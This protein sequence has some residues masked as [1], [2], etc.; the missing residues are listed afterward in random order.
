MLEDL[1][2]YIV[3]APAVA[4]W[5]QWG[6]GALFSTLS[7]A[8]GLQS[9]WRARIID[10]TPT[11]K[12]RSAPQGYV[13]L[14]GTMAPHE[15]GHNG[16]LTGRPCIWYR[17]A[18]HERRG[19]GKN[20]RWV[21]IDGGMSDAPLRLDDGT[22]Q[23]VI[24]P[25][26]AEII[27]AQNDSWYGNSRRPSPTTR[28]SSGLFSGGYRYREERI[29]AGESGYAIGHLHT[30][31][32]G[33]KERDELAGHLLK[34]WKND[35]AA[36]AR[37]DTD[38]DGELSMREWSAAVD[39]AERLASEAEARVKRP[40]PMAHLSATGEKRHPFIIST[41][42]EH[43]LTRRFKLRAAFSTLIF[44]AMGPIT[45]MALYIRLGTT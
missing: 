42:E 27:C 40:P 14:H 8:S 29:S 13:E 32:R 22:G 41:R 10:D 17:W 24:N 21:R 33:R 26:G 3:H 2:H 45:L 12:L 30:P 37:F 1:H 25:D 36:R 16:P 43:D 6:F 34:R 11:A 20:S 5:P 31:R 35:P 7:L 28:T 23:C 39:K 19:S 4:F 38:G 44:M 18:I 9:W 15:G